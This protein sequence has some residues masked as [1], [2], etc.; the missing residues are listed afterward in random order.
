MIFFVRYSYIFPSQGNFFFRRWRIDD[1]QALALRY[2]GTF[3][4]KYKQRMCIIF[5]DL[6]QNMA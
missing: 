2:E 3:D 4:Q 5:A 6:P 1:Q